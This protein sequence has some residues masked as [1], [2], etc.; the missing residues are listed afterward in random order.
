MRGTIYLQEIDFDIKAKPKA[1]PKGRQPEDIPYYS[2]YW[3]WKEPDH[4]PICGFE[5]FGGATCKFCQN[6]FPVKK[7]KVH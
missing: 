3:D 5:S 7:N 6:E 2:Y 4:C 1:K